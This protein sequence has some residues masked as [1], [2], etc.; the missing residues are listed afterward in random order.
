MRSLGAWL[1]LPRR[2]ALLVTYLARATLG[3]VV[4][5]PLV[6]AVAASGVGAF[7]SSDGV[8]FEPGGLFLLE[9]FYR[10]SHALVGAVRASAL[11]L[12]LS[13]IVRTLTSALLFETTRAPQATLIS[14]AAR[15][16]RELPRFLGF[17]GL[18]LVAKVL[19][20]GGAWLAV[21][22]MEPERAA[23]SPARQAT[24][25]VT[26]VLAGLTMM[27][28]AVFADACRAE[29]LRQERRSILGCF[30]ASAALL[31]QHGLLL[32]SGWLLAFGASVF[33]IAGAAR[34]S[35]ALDVGRTGG[36]RVAAVF[37]AHQSTLAL[38]CWI[39]A[40]WIGRVTQLNTD[41][42]R[43]RR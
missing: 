16:L 17:G 12:V 26:L 19:V 4:A 22:L 42:P 10:E 40:A 6:S 7:P 15:A 24:Q 13:W 5:L 30:D 28:I 38:L 41:S 32:G 27:L 1:A 33:A 2:R 37:V 34:V 21:E 25:V 39:Q 20:G 35:E 23:T 9:L 29:L 11:L 3:W 43:A 14:S 36:W 18:E 8:L 31:R